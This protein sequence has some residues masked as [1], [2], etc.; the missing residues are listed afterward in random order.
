MGCSVVDTE[1]HEEEPGAKRKLP[2]ADHRV[3]GTQVCAPSGLAKGFPVIFSAL[4]VLMTKLKK[5]CWDILS[6]AEG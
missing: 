1:T 2:C 4:A 3:R 6:S 5:S